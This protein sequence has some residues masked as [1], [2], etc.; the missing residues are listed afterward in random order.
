MLN[1]QV[2]HLYLY[3]VY[4][5]KTINTICWVKKSNFHK[6]HC[7]SNPNFDRARNLA[8]LTIEYIVIK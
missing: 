4:K 1:R 7:L 5:H 2:M 3:F 8:S 6:K